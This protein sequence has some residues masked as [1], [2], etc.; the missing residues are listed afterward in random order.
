MAHQEPPTRTV[1]ADP[2]AR[3]PLV[4]ALPY[5]MPY[6]VFAVFTVVG[7]YWPQQQALVYAVKTIAVAAVLWHFRRSYTEVRAV[8]RPELLVAAAVGILVIVAWVGLD[9]WYPQTPEQWQA[10]RRGGLQPFDHADKLAGGFNPYREGALLPPP[11]A[12]AFRLFGAVVLVPIFEE[13][14][15][16]SWLIRVVVRGD[17]WHVPIG[18]FTWASFLVSTAVFS[19]THREWL[20]GL[21]CGVAF[22]L[23]LY[24]RK[25]LFVCIVA[26]AVANLALAGYVLT[27]Q[28]WGFW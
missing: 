27:Q 20:A 21:I 19:L 13:L 9:P 23:L 4:V 8:W 1:P 12:I 26:H 6:A 14:F 18:R 10:L 28:A 3:D 22:N 7:G 16:R 5:L 15:V 17:F 11:L 24:W 2:E 25:D